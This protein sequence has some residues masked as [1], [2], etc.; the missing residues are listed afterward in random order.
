MKKISNKKLTFKK[1]NKFERIKLK[2]GAKKKRKIENGLWIR[3][4]YG[5]LYKNRFVANNVKKIQ[6]ELWK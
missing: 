2:H 6:W 1:I 4:W 5:D 3:F